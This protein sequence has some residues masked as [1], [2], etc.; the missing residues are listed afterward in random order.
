MHLP[1]IIALQG[2]TQDWPLPSF[3]KLA[4]LIAV[5]AGFLL[6]CYQAFVR[7]TPIGALLNG[8]RLRTRTSAP[9]A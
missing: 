6:L 8:R 1:L 2:A 4:L 9:A 5:T 7:Y 3:V